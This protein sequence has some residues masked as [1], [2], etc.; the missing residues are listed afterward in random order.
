[1]DQEVQVV[2]L[3]IE[4]FLVCRLVNKKMAIILVSRDAPTFNLM[5]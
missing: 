5:V 3:A 2:L 4:F 1:M